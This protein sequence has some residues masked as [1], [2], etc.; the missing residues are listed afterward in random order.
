M[1]SAIHLY[2]LAVK[3][4][5]QENQ[6]LM[7]Q[8]KN[9]MSKLSFPVRRAKLREKVVLVPIKANETRWSSKYSMLKRYIEI[10]EFLPGLAIH[11]I[12]ESLLLRKEDQQVDAI[13]ETMKKLDSITLCLKRDNT[14]VSQVRV[15]FDTVILHHAEMEDSLKNNADIVE[16]KD[17][18]SELVKDQQNRSRDLS[19]V[20][21]AA[22]EHLRKPHNKGDTKTCN[23]SIAEIAL[24]KHLE[25]QQSSTEYIHSRFIVPTSN[26]CERLFSK[27]SRTLTDCRKSWSST[28]L[29]AQIFLHANDDVWSISDT[30]PIF[31]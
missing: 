14:T 3:D 31:G 26:M 10:R 7:D 19:T 23:L 17:Y 29:E 25:Q 16:C 22:I 9:I 11:E 13:W 12:E 18:E 4:V 21:K 8:I 1:G 28:S 27:A 20:E 24:Q 15:M 6:N 30:N 5:I 2:N